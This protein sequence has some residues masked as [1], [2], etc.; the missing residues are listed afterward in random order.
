MKNKMF[1]IKNKVTFAALVCGLLIISAA[2]PQK[3]SAQFIPPGS[4][5][6]SCENFRTEG[7][8][9][10]ASCKAKDGGK[11][12]SPTKPLT[13][14]FECEGDI[15][16]NDGEFK[17]NRNINSALMQ[18]AIAA[19]NSGYKNVIG[20]EANSYSTQKEI[21]QMLFRDGY[22]QKFYEGKL[23][24]FVNFGLMDYFQTWLSKPE[25]AKVKSEAINRAFR[26][27]YNYGPSPKDVAFYTSSK[28]GFQ[29]I[30]LAEQK[31]L[32]AD[33]VIHRL[34]IAAAYK[35]TMGRNPTA[36]EFDYWLPKQEYFTQIVAA[37]RAYLYAPNGSND[38]VETV[39]RALN[40]NGTNPKPDIDQ[41]N[42]AITKYSQT[43]AIYDEMK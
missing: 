9:L 12:K 15:S 8:N 6:K 28:T 14:Y 31:K 20:V 4:Y 23:G 36:A 34:M 25:N 18:K 40:K 10:I 39:K 5:Q 29:T 17:C 30:V 7:A 27:V 38:L 1:N 35:K 33:K 37:S 16:N 2:A 3:A 24:G 19:I 26:E 32:I 42:K 11:F 21:L 41:I 13:D 43:K 22:A